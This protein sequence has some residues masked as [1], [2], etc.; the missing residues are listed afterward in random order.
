MPYLPIDFLMAFSLLSAM[1]ISY[2]MIPKVVEISK[3]KLLV[4]LPNGRTSHT[5][6]IPT[7]G[8]IAIFASIITGAGLFM[9]TDMPGEFQFMVPALVL[10]FFIGLQDDIAGIRARDKLAGQIIASLIVIIGANVRITTLHSFLGIEEIP[11]L[12]SVLLT[13]VIFVGLINAFNLIDGIDGLA[14]GLGI[15]ISAVFSIWLFMLGKE[16]YAILACALTGSL[17]AFFHFNV[18]GARNKLFMGDT[19]SMLIGMIFAILAVNV[20]S[21]PVPT[22]SFLYMKAF[23]VVVMSLMIIPVSDTLR[24]MILRMLNG[25]RPFSA[26]R[27]HL[28][29]DLLRMG[30]THLQA[31]VI[32]VLANLRLFLLALAIRNL[33]CEVAGF[34]MLGSGILVCSIPRIW[35]KS[36]RQSSKKLVISFS[37]LNWSDKNIA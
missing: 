14:S 7:L 13:L 27:T 8:G 31:S 5:G 11:Y 32:I 22:N 6:A 21:C 1:I 28:H 33:P 18:F 19:G 35:L 36:I 23:P 15:V 20:L 4:A 24:V 10:L 26:D 37:A 12:V 17:I 29:H 16:H 25:K 2:T 3:A 30:F 34:I 9:P